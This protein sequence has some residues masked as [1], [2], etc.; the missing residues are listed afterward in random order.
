MDE[1]NQLQLLHKGPTAGKSWAMS[2]AGFYSER[3]DLRMGKTAAQQQLGEKSERCERNRPAGT[4]V[5]EGGGQKVLQG[6]PCSPG[7][8]HGR[9]GCAPTACGH[10]MGQISTCSQGGGQGAAVDEAWRRTQP[11][12]SPCRN[13][14]GPELQPVERNP[15]WGR[16]FTSPLAPSYEPNH[17]VKH[18]MFY[19]MTYYHYGR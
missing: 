19:L 11:M 7:E 6:V 5:S 14:P 3:E 12:E 4:K 2:N 18:V 13:S 1:Q 8:A 17:V 10:H 16:N 15:W 9:T